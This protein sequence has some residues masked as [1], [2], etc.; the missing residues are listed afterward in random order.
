MDQPTANTVSVNTL[1]PVFL[2][3]ETLRV[4]LVGGGN[5][6][7]EKLRAMKDNAP[8]TSIHLVATVIS[9]EVKKF[10]FDHPQ[11]QLTE[12]PFT[13][14]DLDNAD[15]VIVAVNDQNVSSQIK[16]LANQKK[17]LVNVADQPALCDFYLGSIVRKGNLKIA[18]STNGKS[19]T[20]AKR[21]KEV[22]Q[23]LIPDSFNQ[24][25]DQMQQIRAKLNGDFA[26]KVEKLNDITRELAESESAIPKSERG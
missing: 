23:E 15:L 19:P 9:A 3:L 2:K 24:V 18:I 13:E 22:F 14:S 5:V 10:A 21:L 26:R 16:S 6:A 12:R 1:F 20:I 11:I 4:L 17:L 25:L 8:A 7:M